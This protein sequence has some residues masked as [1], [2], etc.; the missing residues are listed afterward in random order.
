MMSETAVIPKP[1]ISMPSNS[2]FRW[3][4]PGSFLFGRL[5][6]M[7]LPV[8]AIE[9]RL[10]LDFGLTGLT[11]SDSDLLRLAVLSIEIRFKRFHKSSQ[12]DELSSIASYSAL[13]SR[14]LFKAFLTVE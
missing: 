5:R 1:N 10:R 9:L 3:N 14:H 11:S 4:S 6:E 2:N 7:T 12:I 8:R 13:L